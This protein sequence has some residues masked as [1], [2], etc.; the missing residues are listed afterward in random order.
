M[1]AETDAIHADLG[2]LAVIAAE[3]ILAEARYDQTSAAINATLQQL[4]TA[5]TRLRATDPHRG[6]AAAERL[7]DVND[8]I[9]HL[10]RLSGQRL[11]DLTDFADRRGRDLDAVT[12]RINDR[13][14]EPPA[15]GNLK[16]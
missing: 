4:Q 2:A 16:T 12:A 8:T 1:V 9:T 14:A 10:I 5:I 7:G 13:A 6:A 15:A 11:T 3:E